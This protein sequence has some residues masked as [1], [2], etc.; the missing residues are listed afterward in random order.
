MSEPKSEGRKRFTP[1]AMAAS[2]K[3]SLFAVFWDSGDKGVVAFEG[4]H[5]GVLRVVVDPHGLHAGREAVCLAASGECCHCEAA[6]YEAFDDCWADVAS[7]S[8][9]GYFVVCHDCMLACDEDWS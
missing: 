4:L 1:A 7:G 6:V 5:Q 3:G 2:M 8:C 9:D